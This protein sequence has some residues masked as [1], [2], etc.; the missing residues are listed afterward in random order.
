MIFTLLELK[1]DQFV[2]LDVNIGYPLT[3]FTAYIYFD[4]SLKNTYWFNPI[5]LINNILN[6]FI[7]FKL[8]FLGT[9]YLKGFKNR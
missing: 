8:L 2:K 4:E 3:F 7:S 6:F 5:A 9:T 1:T